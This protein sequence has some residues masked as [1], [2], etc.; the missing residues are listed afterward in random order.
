LVVAGLVSGVSSPGLT[1][2][3]LFRSIDIATR[4]NVYYIY[5]DSDSGPFLTHHDFDTNTTYYA[6][7]TAGCGG[8]C[9]ATSHTCAVE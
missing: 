5:T 3:F 1:H 7:S 2:A 6:A 4:V 9:V 8:I